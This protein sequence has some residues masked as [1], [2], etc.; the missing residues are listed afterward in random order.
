MFRHRIVVFACV[1][2]I[3]AT[4]CGGAGT[5]VLPTA[6]TCGD[7][8][9]AGIVDKLSSGYRLY[10][11]GDEDS[12]PFALTDKTYLWSYP[13][14]KYERAPAWSPDGTRLLYI[15]DEDRALITV[16]TQGRDAREIAVGRIQS[17]VWSPDGTKIAFIRHEGDSEGAS[18]SSASS[19]ISVVTS[20]GRQ[21]LAQSR[22]E[23][24]LYDL[25]WSPDGA[26]LTYSIAL[27][28]DGNI[29]AIHAINTDLTRDYPLVTHLGSADV[30]SILRAG[31]WS[32]DGERFFYSGRYDPGNFLQDPVYE[33]RYVSRDGTT[34][35]IISSSVTPSFYALALSPSGEWLAFTHGDNFQVHL[36]RTDGS[37][38]H[39]L[40][41]GGAGEYLP[42]W[43]PDGSRLLIWQKTGLAWIDFLPD[44]IGELQ[45]VSID[46]TQTQVI[47]AD[48]T[49]WNGPWS[50]AWRPAAP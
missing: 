12:E 30:W 4:G 45:S 6:P 32:R 19:E 37:E 43:S 25:T 29:G 21:I 9:F 16:D 46:G 38:L 20:D 50:A 31:V 3:A 40:R 23:Q 5:H 24:W 14:E 18:L 34:L 11:T 48:V 41:P 22:Q 44:Q 10:C 33:L 47:A 13:Y 39:A 27:A 28:Y 2:L 8:V 7:I 15:S 49:S 17:A 35:G 1:L 26:L 36:I 42:T